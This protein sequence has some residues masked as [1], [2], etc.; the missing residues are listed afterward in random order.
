M[1]KVN[2]EN[3]IMKQIKNGQVKLKSKYLFLAEKISLG[4]GLILLIL[5][6]IFFLNL[7]LFYI[8]STDNLEYLSFGKG[9]SLAFLETF[10]YHWLLIC[11][12]SLI[13][14]G[15][16]VN[17]YN[18]AYKKPF[19]YT[20]S[21]I[22]LMATLAGGL[23]AYSQMNNNLEKMLFADYQHKKFL[24]PFYR[25]HFK[26]RKYGIAG[27]IIEIE[28][29]CLML[30]NPRGLI[31]VLFK[32]PVKLYNNE[33]Q[34]NNFVLVVGKHKKDYFEA[35]NIKKVEGARMPLISRRT[36]IFSSTTKQ[37]M[38][39]ELQY[40]QKQ[41]NCLK[42]CFNCKTTTTTIQQC[43]SKCPKNQ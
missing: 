23:L 38:S 42:N 2:L 24:K 41:D 14:A 16:L 15:Y 31:K 17:R 11:V 34:Q 20:A 21:A 8:K 19:L 12:A 22:I 27:I 13:I 18:F 6:A 7:S 40:L 28:D 37:R 32:K 36:I 29:N 5:L 35:K 4:S 43:N 25:D 10:P 9:G 39:S 3:K 1:N 30:K 33:I 26:K